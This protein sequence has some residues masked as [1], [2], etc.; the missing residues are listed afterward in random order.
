M[1]NESMKDFNRMLNEPME[2]KDADVYITAEIKI[3]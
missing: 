1:A 3:S 2:P